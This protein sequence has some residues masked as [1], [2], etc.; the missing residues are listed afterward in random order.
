MGDIT[1]MATSSGHGRSASER[2]PRTSDVPFSAPFGFESPG[3][4][5]SSSAASS[6]KRR[7]SPTI[8]SAVPTR[9]SHSQVVPPTA[10]LRARAICSL[11]TVDFLT[12]R[13]F[14]TRADYPIPAVTGLPYECQREKH[15]DA[16][17]EKHQARRFG[18]CCGDAT[19]NLVC[20]P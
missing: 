5:F 18:D 8:V 20:H 4:S 7:N 2:T 6:R 13:T 9:V 14:L 15:C 3:F 10:C 11:V 12:A 1:D 19:E 17:C 16:T